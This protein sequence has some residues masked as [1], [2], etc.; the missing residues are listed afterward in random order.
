[1]NQLDAVPL[2]T[3]LRFPSGSWTGFFL[4]CWM[5]GRQTMAIDFTFEAEHLQATGSDIVG[6]FT[7]EGQYNVAD[8]KCRWI[9][10]Y[11]GKHSVTYTGVNEG[12]GIWGVWEIRLLAGLYQDQGVFHIWPQGMTP[13]KETEATVQAYLAHLRATWPLRILRLFGLVLVVALFAALQVGLIQ[14]F[15]RVWSG[16]SLP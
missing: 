4:Q 1:M 16:S 12:Q 10:K 5:P 11:L 13:T 15:F 7:F 6:P 3:D 2:E 14:H 9:K 8:G